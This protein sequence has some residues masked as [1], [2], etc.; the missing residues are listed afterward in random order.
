MNSP[1]QFQRKL[2]DPLGVGNQIDHA[3]ASFGDRKAERN[4]DR[5]CTEKENLILKDVSL[6]LYNTAD[7]QKAKR[8]FGELL[9]VEPYADAAA[10]VGY[11]YGSLEIGLTPY[12]DKNITG[13]LAYWDVDDIAATIKTLMD[14]GGTVVQDITDVGYGLQ[15]ASVKDP[16]GA[17]V[18]LR[19]QPNG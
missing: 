3:D 6:I 18:G 14:A 9:G 7:L 8:F 15:V 10:Y 1:R 13:G 5:L 4:P 11:K 17:I 2:I 16:N 19:Q 12:G